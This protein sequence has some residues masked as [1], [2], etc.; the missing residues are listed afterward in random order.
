MVNRVSV[1]A[2]G[3]RTVVRGRLVLEDGSVFEGTS[4]GAERSSAGEVVFSTGMVGYPETLTDPSFCGQVVTFTYPLIGNYGVPRAREVEGIN[5][6]MESDRVH[7]RGVICADYSESYSHWDAAGSLGE[8]L[9]EQGVPALTGIDTRALT[10]RLRE[11][12]SMLGKIVIEDEE[13]DYYDPNI[14][15]LGERV[16]IKEPITYGTGAKRVALVDCGA[17]HNIIMSLVSRGV[18]VVRVPWDTDLSTV[19]YDGLFLS[20]GPGNPRFF[21][22]TI[23]QVR[24][25]MG[26]GKPLM[27]ICLG[28]Q[29]LALAAGA[30]TYKL[31]YGHRSQNQPVIEV[32]T[33]RCRLTSQNHGFAVATSTLGSEWKPWFENLNDGTNEGLMHE[34]GKIRSVQFHPEA[35]PGPTDTAYLFDDFARMVTA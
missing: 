34:S 1:E 4:F 6:A 5:L 33:D 35:C 16:S 32:G 23:E 15:N 2:D 7:V 21:K 9:I 24:W 14:E 3:G 25:A 29:L 22:K 13:I 30:S 12:G 11:R 28:H 8:L 10:E 20:N 18:Q 27:G 31:K 26:Q 19:E 17:K